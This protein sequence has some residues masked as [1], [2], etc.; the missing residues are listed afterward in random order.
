MFLNFFS[1]RNVFNAI[2]SHVRNNNKLLVFLYSAVFIALLIF[3]L[4]IPIAFADED[5]DEQSNYREPGTVTSMEAFSQRGGIDTP[6]ALLLGAQYATE[7]GHYEDAI[8]IC[9][10]ALK[11]D[12]EDA[13]LHKIFADALE[14]KLRRQKEPDPTLFNECVREWLIVYRGL[15]GEDKGMGI[16]GINPLGH[17]FE[18]EDRAIPARYHLVKLTGRA[19]RPWESNMKYL[20]KVLKPTESTVAGKVLHTN[21]SENSSESSA[22]TSK[23]TKEDD[24]ANAKE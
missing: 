23:N 21:S 2:R 15:V 10:Q 6:G 7:M 11:V 12:Y 9:R 17:L 22:E 24:Q 8:K 13:D 20:N 3:F 5:N 1:S 14:Q 19:P 18:D 16:N 4:Q